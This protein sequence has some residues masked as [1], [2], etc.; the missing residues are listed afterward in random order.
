MIHRKNNSIKEVMRHKE[1]VVLKEA[2]P[3]NHCHDSL[4]LAKVNMLVSCSARVSCPL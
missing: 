3:L 4:R 2:E 1:C